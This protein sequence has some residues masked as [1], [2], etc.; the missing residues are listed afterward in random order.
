MANRNS[1]RR[2]PT[3]EAMEGRL[4]LSSM[5][6]PGPSPGGHH[7]VDPPDRHHDVD[8][9]DHHHDVDPPGHHHDVDP[10]GKH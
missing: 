7:D 3:L 1:R 9:P 5:I 2:R 8:P 10:P 4:A 6:G